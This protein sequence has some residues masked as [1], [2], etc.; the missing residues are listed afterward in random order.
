MRFVQL[1][2]PDLPRP[3]PLLSPLLHSAPL[4]LGANA[5]VLRDSTV[6]HSLTPSA[7]RLNRDSAP[8]TDD[9][10]SQRVSQINLPPLTPLTS[11]A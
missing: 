2:E 8:V 1:D 4:C 10:L 3:R 5:E 6:F 11:A 9:L 7:E